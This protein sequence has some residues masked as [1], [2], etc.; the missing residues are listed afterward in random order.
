MLTDK[1]TLAERVVG[2]GEGWLTSLS[3]AELRDL[4]ALAPEAIVD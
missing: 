4:L 3:T 1:G 2:N